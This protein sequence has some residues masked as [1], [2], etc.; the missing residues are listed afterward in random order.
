MIEHKHLI[1]KGF[2]QGTMTKT[3]IRHFLNDLI[4][5]LDMKL[6][7]LPNNPNIGYVGGEGSGHTGVAIITT[8]H[9]V[10]HC[11]EKTME[12]QLD[13]YSCKKF[14]PATIIAYCSDERFYKVSARF[15]DRNYDIITDEDI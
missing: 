2:Y 14:D 10:L 6:M 1:V 8:S 3:R 11:W 9:I 15:F 4:F 5:L 12:Y 13:V 7:E